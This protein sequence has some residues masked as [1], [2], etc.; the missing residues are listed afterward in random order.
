MD[1]DKISKYLTNE[2]TVDEKA[3]FEALMEQNAE[4]KETIQTSANDLK[5]IQKYHQLQTRYNTQKAWNKV[6]DNI[7]AQEHKKLQ[8]RLISRYAAAV[9]ILITIGVTI[10]LQY[11]NTQP[12][13]VENVQPTPQLITL[14]D[15][16]MVTLK[17]G[18]QLKYPKNFK[19]H[20][21]RIAFEGEAYFEITPNRNAPFYIET[22]DA[23]IS[24]LG[25]SFNVNTENARIQ[26][27]V[28]SGSVKITAENT[29]QSVTLA[30]G[31]F[32]SIQH[33][34]LQKYDTYNS[35][36]LA[37][38]THLLIFN[39][40]PIHE[41]NQALEHSYNIQIHWPEDMNANVLF[42]STFDNETLDVI[43]ESIATAF[44]FNYKIDQQTIYF[45]KKP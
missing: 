3:D 31:D 36:I 4:Y 43:M 7:Q 9:L 1:W 40:T 42:T 32:G 33:N 14:P 35:N 5:V 10:Y 44:Q 38:R 45:F 18:A 15:G 11:K 24:V 29:N 41:V 16:S 2:M 27:A 28:T 6:S 21:R 22:H 20:E 17:N 8:V 37:W 13:L 19:K 30:A 23:L 26:V 25:T 34:D 39:K 12:I